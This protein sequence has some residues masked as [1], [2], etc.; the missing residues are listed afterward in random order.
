MASIIEAGPVIELIQLVVAEEYQGLGLAGVLLRRLIQKADISG[1]AKV[2][3][4]LSGRFLDATKL[5]QKAGFQI[6]AQSMQLDL[7]QWEEERS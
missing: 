1:A 6:S 4:H 2:Q 3:I 5:F 7:S